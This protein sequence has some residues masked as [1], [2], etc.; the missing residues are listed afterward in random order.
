[1]E[2]NSVQRLTMKQP[3]ISD[4]ELLEA[5]W[6]FYDHWEDHCLDEDIQ[7]LLWRN[8]WVFDAVGVYQEPDESDPYPSG[9]I[10]WTEPNGFEKDSNVSSS[11]GWCGMSFNEKCEEV[12]CDDIQSPWING[13]WGIGDSAPRLHDFIE[14]LETLLLLPQSIWPPEVIARGYS[15]LT[16]ARYLNRLRNQGELPEDMVMEAMF[17]SQAWD[18][19]GLLSLDNKQAM[20]EDNSAN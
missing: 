11:K 19:E 15:R 4:N 16:Q 10:Q 13:C 9:F 8:P 18:P 3:T 5:G 6:R 1:M 20:I 2:L 7:I 17:S 12:I 14:R